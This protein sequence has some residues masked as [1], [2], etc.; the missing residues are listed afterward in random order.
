MVLDSE[1]GRAS[2]LKS[3]SALSIFWIISL[4]GLLLAGLSASNAPFGQG[5][6]PI[7]ESAAVYEALFWTAVLMIPVYLGLRIYSQW[8]GG[9]GLVLRFMMGVVCGGATAMVLQAFVGVCLG[10]MPH[11]VNW[12]SGWWTIGV[13]GAFILAP[14]TFENDGSIDILTIMAAIVVSILFLL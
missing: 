1:Y 2:R 10:G 7:D 13:M 14:I 11:L 8:T 9:M 12:Q 4:V 3:F 5:A 6:Y